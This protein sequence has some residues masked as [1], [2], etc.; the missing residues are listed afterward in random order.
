MKLLFSEPINKDDVHEWI[1]THEQ[2]EIEDWITV[3]IIHNENESCDNFYDDSD[4][5][6]QHLK[7]SRVGGFK[8]I[9]IAT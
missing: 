5:E 6:N 7:I 9:K 1:N 4:D 3:N 8:A 2:K